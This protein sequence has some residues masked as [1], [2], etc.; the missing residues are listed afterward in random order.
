MLF[1]GRFPLCLFFSQVRL[2]GLFKHCLEVALLS[3][4]FEVLFELFMVCFYR[5]GSDSV[6]YYARP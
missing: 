2:D 4:L 6:G 5:K 3:I 1:F